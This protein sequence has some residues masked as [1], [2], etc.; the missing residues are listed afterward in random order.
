[1]N[2]T[3]TRAGGKTSEFWLL[4]AFFGIVLANGT[5]AISI[6]TDQMTMLATLAG[7]WAG[8]RTLLKNS[9]AKNGGTT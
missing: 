4:L 2:E 5:A 9:L 6:P 3:V 7:G 8:G 1:M